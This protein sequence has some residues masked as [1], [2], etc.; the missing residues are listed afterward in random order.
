M[1]RNAWSVSN[2]IPFNNLLFK[3]PSLDFPR[4]NTARGGGGVMV[5]LGGNNKKDQYTTDMIVNYQM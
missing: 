3:F 1:C 4:P 2:P 5:D